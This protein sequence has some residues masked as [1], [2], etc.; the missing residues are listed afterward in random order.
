MNASLQDRPLPQIH[1]VDAGTTE[2]LQ[3]LWRR[4][5]QAYRAL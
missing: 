2:L 1:G 5:V 3:L 4:L